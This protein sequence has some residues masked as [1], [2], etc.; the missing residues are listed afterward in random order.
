MKIGCRVMESNNNMML[1][2]DIRSSTAVV[3]FFEIT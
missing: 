1:G 2:W 3:C